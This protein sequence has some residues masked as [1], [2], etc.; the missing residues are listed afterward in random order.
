MDK[1]KKLFDLVQKDG[2][3]RIVGAHDPLGAKLI[4]RA[5]F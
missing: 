1:A 3:V 4:E 2:V 5:G